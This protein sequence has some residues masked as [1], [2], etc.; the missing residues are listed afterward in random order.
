MNTHEFIPI[1][2]RVRWRDAM[3]IEDH[4]E[5]WS[6]SGACEFFDLMCASHYREVFLIMLQP[7]PT[8][9]YEFRQLLKRLLYSDDEPVSFIGKPLKN[10]NHESTDQ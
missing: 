4:E 6:L 10:Y 1:I 7:S 2:Y 5:F 9:R 8:G 3:C